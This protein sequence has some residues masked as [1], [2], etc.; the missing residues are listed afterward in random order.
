LHTFLGYVDTSVK[1]SFQK[2]RDGST[3]PKAMKV[4]AITAAEEALSSKMNL[5]V[6]LRAVS[7]QT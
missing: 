3:K 5:I 7:R 1:R 2:F 6:T 4:A